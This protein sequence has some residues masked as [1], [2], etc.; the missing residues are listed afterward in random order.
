MIDDFIG[1]VFGYWTVIEKA[2]SNNPKDKHKMYKCRCVCGNEHIIRKSVLVHGKSLS[3]GCNGNVLY[4]NK[5]FGRLTCTSDAF[6]IKDNTGNNRKYVTVQ[7]DCGKIKD[8]MT[9]ALDSG[10]TISCGC[11]NKEILSTHCKENHHNYNPDLTDEER[12]ANNSRMSNNGY[13]TF[14]RKVLRKYD[15]TCQVC[16]IKKDK[17]MRVHHMYSWNINKDKRFDI[18]NAIVLCSECHDIQYNGS[19]HNIYGNGNN[20]PEQIYE[21][22][23]MRKQEAV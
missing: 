13:Q 1:K 17:N 6:Y 3:C 19:F 4:K 15:N 12:L 18:D 9:Q 10:V 14:R 7:C 21:Y 8:V 5:R 20:T 22:I 11:Y 2:K 23:E 16:G